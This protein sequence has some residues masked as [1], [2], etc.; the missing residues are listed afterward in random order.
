VPGAYRFSHDALAI[1]SGRHLIGFSASARRQ[2]GGR[3]A[4][5]GTL[6]PK[7]DQGSK[8]VRSGFG[9]VDSGSPGSLP[10]GRLSQRPVNRIGPWD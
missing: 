10:T 1:L 4:G 7:P 2:E 6:A 9:R 8:G 3:P 5:P